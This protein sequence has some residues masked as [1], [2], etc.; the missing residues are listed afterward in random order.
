MFQALFE[1]LNNHS[2]VLI[3][4][5]IIFIILEIIIYLKKYKSL[6]IHIIQVAAECLFVILLMQF[7]DTIKV[8]LGLSFIPTSFINFMILI[9]ISIILIKKSF[10]LIN[11]LEKYQVTRGNN[12]TS[13]HIIARVIKV[14]VFFSIILIFGQQ[15][16]LSISGL[17]AFGG[18]GSIIIGMA[19]KEVISNFLSGIILYFDRPF[20]NGDWIS[21]PDKNIAGT[22]IEIGWRMTKILTFDHRPLYVPNSLFSSI[23][24]EN[25]SHM[26]HRRVDFSLRLRYQDTD[27]ISPIIEDIRALLKQDPNIDT[28]QTLLVYFNEVTDSSLNI[29]VYCFTK[30]V[31]WAEW[32]AAQQNIY[33]NIINIIK[34]HDAEL[35]YPTQNIYLDK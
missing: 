13:A 31:V 28:E 2:I 4:Y 23:T 15:F 19:G 6:F 29:M 17:M 24:I 22:V 21:S 34:S 16:G 33:F 12:P 32:L 1:K 9:F 8:K 10:L 14:F 7:I 25:N 30:T 11:R 5:L 35:A 20:N 27:K 26:T 3:L 18:F